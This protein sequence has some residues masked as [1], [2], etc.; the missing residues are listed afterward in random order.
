MIYLCFIAVKDRCGASCPMLLI[1][2]KETYWLGKFECVLFEKELQYY[3]TAYM[4]VLAV[5]SL[6]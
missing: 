3:L 6:S 2:V 1:N 4:V 5:A